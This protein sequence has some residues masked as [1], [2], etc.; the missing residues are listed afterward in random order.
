MA[1]PET[2]LT[3][4]SQDISD[5]INKLDRKLMQNLEALKANAE[6]LISLK[7]EYVS[8]LETYMEKSL[9]TS[10]ISTFPGMAPPTPNYEIMNKDSAK[11]TQILEVMEELGPQVTSQ[12]ANITKTS[13]L[14]SAEISNT[15]EDIME[16]NN[17]LDEKIESFGV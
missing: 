17:I 6:K 13:K 9:D 14:L 11:V 10:G 5:L 16:L 7:I 3:E 15:V 4:I 8:L 12:L 1:S 2:I